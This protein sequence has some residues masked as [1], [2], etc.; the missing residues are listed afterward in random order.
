MTKLPSRSLS[1]LLAS[2]LLGAALLGAGC[3]A[4]LPFRRDVPAG[5]SRPK[6]S[7]VG[8]DSTY[9]EAYL[10][11]RAEQRFQAFVAALDRGDGS[12]AYAMVSSQQRD[13][14][15]LQALTPAQL[16]SIADI[17]RTYEFGGVWGSRVEFRPTR[18]SDGDP[19]NSVYVDFTPGAE[20][21]AY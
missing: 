13:S 6:A 11:P 19:M 20:G 5:D 1:L 8:A 10:R 21:I 18:I 7:S 15:F 14:A 3:V 16:H 9:A 17:Y 4:K 2:I 12:A